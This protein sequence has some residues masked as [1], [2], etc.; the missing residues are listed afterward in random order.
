MKILL[1]TTL[2]FC[3]A[4]VASQTWDSF[5][6][7]ATTSNESVE[8][9]QPLQN[10]LLIAG[11]FSGDLALG[12]QSISGTGTTDIFLSRVSTQGDFSWAIF[13]QSNQN[14]ASDA[15]AQAPDG[16]LYWAGIFW[17]EMTLAGETLI[18]PEGGRAIFL[19]AIDPSDGS[20]LWNQIIGGTGFKDVGGLAVG[21]NGTIYLSGRFSQQ[22]TVGNQQLTAEAETDLLLAAFSAEGQVEWTS[23]SGTTGNIV[24]QSLQVHPISG[25]ILVAGFYNGTFNW[26]GTQLESLTFDN[27]GF[28]IAAHPDGT[29]SWARKVGA[30]YDDQ[31]RDLIVHPDGTIFLTGSF[32]GVLEIDTNWEITTPGFNNN[33]FLIAYTASGSP[34][35]ARSLGGAENEEGIALSLRNGGPIVCGHFNNSFSVDGQT[36]SGVGPTLNSFYAGFRADG[37]LRWLQALDGE[38]LVLTS[39]ITVDADNAVWASGSFSGSVQVNGTTTFSEGLFD[40]YWGQLRQEVTY[41]QNLQKA[42]VRLF[43]NPA[44]D[45]V[46][47]EGITEN[48][49]IQLV[50]SAGRSWKIQLEGVQLDLTRFPSGIYWI[51]CEEQAPVQLLLQR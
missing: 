6:Q 44:T 5:Q 33:L 3:W 41:V 37:S 45:R 1:L 26:A 11:I 24:P 10:D 29:S 12:N 32:L 28:L 16:T 46:T 23:Q 22:L 50:N 4:T 14:D 15:I 27:D 21:A 31:P 36:I 43:P 13:G 25:E 8:Q 30:Q 49:W 42:T 35:W 18:A 20:I 39:D 17:D 19:L 34:I 48:S 38:N 2:I 7:L 40:G 47:L 51:Y 9:I